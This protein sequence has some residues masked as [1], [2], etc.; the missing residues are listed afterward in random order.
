MRSTATVELPAHFVSLEQEEETAIAG[1]WVFLGS[2][3]LFF[4]AIMV[5][6]GVYRI[7]YWEGFSE[8]TSQLEMLVAAGNTVVL[9]ASGF[10]MALAVLL[11]RIQA[12]F[13]CLLLLL[14][15]II[16][17][18]AFLCLKGYEYVS[19][20]NKGLVPGDHFTWTGPHRL[21]VELFFIF[22]FILTGLH[23]IHLLIGIGVL[24]VFGLLVLIGRVNAKR[25]HPLH[26]AG[27]YW[28]FVDV[29]WIFI[30]AL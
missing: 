10:T 15:T 16:L 22:Y 8:A 24:S 14:F 28:H 5:A 3:V 2:E 19:D 12:K 4:G 27:I 17:G 6:F 13:F 11:L 7:L 1:M 29:V 21:Q 23:A 25:S 20:W 18:I 26:V 30:F 9:F